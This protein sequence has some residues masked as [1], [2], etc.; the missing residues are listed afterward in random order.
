MIYQIPVTKRLAPASARPVTSPRDTPE[1]LPS[2]LRALRGRLS[3][4]AGRALA[5]GPEGGFWTLAM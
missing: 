4:F 5:V 3:R 1:Y 2:S